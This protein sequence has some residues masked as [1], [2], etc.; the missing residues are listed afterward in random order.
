MAPGRDRGP[1]DL[2]VAGVDGQPGT[3]GG[4]LVGQGLDGRARPGPAPRRCPTGSAPGR[5]DSP[6]TSTT[7]APSASSLRPWRTAASG[8]AQRAT[9]GEG[10]RGDVQ[11]THDQRS[12][13]RVTLPTARRSGPGWTGARRPRLWSPAGG[14]TKSGEIPALTRNGDAHGPRAVVESGRTL[15]RTNHVTL[16]ARGW[17]DRQPLSI[18]R[19]GPRR[20]E[21]PN[22]APPSAPAARRV[23]AALALVLAACGDD[24]DTVASSGDAAT[25]E[26][27]R[28]AETTEAGP[29][30]RSRVP[31]HRHRRRDRHHDRGRARRRSC[32]CRRRPPRCCS[33]SAPATRSSPSTTSRTSPRRRPITD[34]SGLRPERRGD[35]R[36]RARPGGPVRR[37]QRR[38]GR[39]RRRRR[40]RPSCSTP[41]PPSTTPT[42][43]SRCSAPPPA[44]SA[45]PPSWSPSMQS[46]IDE[47]AAQ[48]PERDEPLTYYHELDDTLFSVTSDTFI[49]EIYALGRP[50]EHRRRRRR[51]GRGRGLPA[52]LRR[53]HH[54][55]RPRPDLPR[56]HQ[57]LRPGRRPPS[58]PGRAGPT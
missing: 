13:R 20:Q 48:V 28:R 16:E 49:G 11:D 44:T 39:P 50:R 31:R 17:F 4:D 24:D 36:L 10:V 2:G 47:L 19:T 38:R 43:R 26:D 45:T 33:P 21:E 15:H 14:V 55:R 41:R 57:V 30:R 25:S 22:C 37:P 29:P 1:G 3:G 27:R 51:C 35:H 23:L 7:S 6:P 42:P 58:P 32:R 12:H 18:E 5:V 8:S 46:D 52:A 54:R 56:R 9:V 40:A 53:V 34:L